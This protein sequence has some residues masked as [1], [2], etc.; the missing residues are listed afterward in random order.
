MATSTVY[1]KAV[2]VDLVTH[3]TNQGKGA[4]IRSGLE[5]ARG[6][7]VLIQDADLEYDPSEY[8]VLVAPFFIDP[9]CTVVYGSR[10]RGDAREMI[11]W[12][13]F[14][15]RFVTSAFNH[16]YGTHLTDME[17]CYKAIRR[18]ALDGITLE[19]DRW[20]FDP[21]ITA[22]LVMAGQD[23]VEVPVDYSG[24]DFRH[25]KKLRWKDG[26]TV[27]QA[28]V[29]YRFRGNGKTGRREDGET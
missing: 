22:K 16:L 25:G 21:E 27:L 29:R 23:I 14:G 2:S 13:R 28:I 20:G 8:R 19:S 4:A 15:N 17:T 5:H 26:F 12:H 6:E 7:I 9:A 3:A 24:R 10:F 11:A 1:F 18:S